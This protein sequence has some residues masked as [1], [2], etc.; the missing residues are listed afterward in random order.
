MLKK[1]L[2][3]NGYKYGTSN[4]SGF[5]TKT[6]TYLLTGSYANIAC[7]SCKKESHQLLYYHD[8]RLVGRIDYTEVKPVQEEAESQSNNKSSDQKTKESKSVLGTIGK[9]ILII[10]LVI[11]GLAIAGYLFLVCYAIYRRKQRRKQRAAMRQKKRDS[12]YR[13]FLKENND[14]M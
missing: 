12:E 9:V 8:E 14:D 2:Y 4:K 13:R 5:G 11:V 6:A 10:F 3:T 7:E 1:Y